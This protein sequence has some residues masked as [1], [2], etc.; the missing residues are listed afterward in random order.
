MTPTPSLHFSLY[1]FSFHLLFLSLPSLSSLRLSHPRLCLSVTSTLV[2]VT[3]LSLCPN[4]RYLSILPSLSLSLLSPSLFLPLSFSFSHWYLS[5]MPCLAVAVLGTLFILIILISPSCLAL[6]DS[7]MADTHLS[8]LLCYLPITKRQ[9][10]V[11]RLLEARRSLTSK[12]WPN[13]F[14]YLLPSFFFHTL[15]RKG[16]NNKNLNTV[17]VYE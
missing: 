17:C 16:K 5:T 6:R 10:R 12:R 13:L 14:F 1:S 15:P 9:S 4:S 7:L 8:I 2:S 11:Q 3:H